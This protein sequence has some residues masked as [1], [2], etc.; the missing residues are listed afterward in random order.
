MLYLYVYLALILPCFLFNSTVSSKLRSRFVKYE[1]NSYSGLVINF[2]SQGTTILANDLFGLHCPWSW[3][4]AKKCRLA[5][6]K[7]DLDLD[8][9]HHETLGHLTAF[10]CDDLSRQ[11][12]IAREAFVSRKV[13]WINKLIRLPF[14]PIVSIFCLIAL[15]NRDLFFYTER[16]PA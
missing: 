11:E 7:E 1:G 4:V 5:A 9:L 14:S 13:F 2:F 8:G 16:D 10:D 6:L 15:I 3:E 12:S